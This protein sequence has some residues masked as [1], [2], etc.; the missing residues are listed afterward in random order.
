MKDSVR[1]R[2]LPVGNP[3]EFIW[4]A[5]SVTDDIMIYQPC[6][7]RKG[8]KFPVTSDKFSL[9]SRAQC[10]GDLQQLLCEPALDAYAAMHSA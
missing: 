3:S 6:V 2:L 5:H 10:T 8:G 7:R 4:A 1:V 9:D